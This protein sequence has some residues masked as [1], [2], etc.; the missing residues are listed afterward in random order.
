MRQ[1]VADSERRGF[2]G[3]PRR[4]LVAGGID[5]VERDVA[6]SIAAIPNRP[7]NGFRASFGYSANKRDHAAIADFSLAYLFANNRTGEDRQLARSVLD[8]LCVGVSPSERRAVYLD[9]LVNR[10]VYPRSGAADT[11]HPT[12]GMV[13]LF[14]SAYGP[15]DRIG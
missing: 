1:V 6:G 7:L 9:D 3:R 13:G 14:R 2:P 11:E 8:F 4:K 10:P 12:P 5:I 15:P